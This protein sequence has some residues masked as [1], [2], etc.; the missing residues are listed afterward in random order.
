MKEWFDGKSCLSKLDLSQGEKRAMKMDE[1]QQVM[2]CCQGLKWRHKNAT[3][4]VKFLY[5]SLKKKKKQFV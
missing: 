4:F 1:T 3:K 2:F 5:V